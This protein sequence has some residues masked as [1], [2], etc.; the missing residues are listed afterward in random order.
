MLLSFSMHGDII[1]LSVTQLQW[2]NGVPYLRALRKLSEK[3]LRRGST[4][5]TDIIL[6]SVW[7]EPTAAHSSSIIYIKGE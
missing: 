6:R 7:F 4:A 1:L 2:A 3:S 5:E